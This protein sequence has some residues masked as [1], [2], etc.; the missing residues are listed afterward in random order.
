[1]AQP[2]FVQLPV[3]LSQHEI[4]TLGKGAFVAKQPLFP[5]HTADQMFK[6]DSDKSRGSA[7]P[8]DVGQIERQITFFD[9]GIINK[10]ATEKQGGNNGMRGTITCFGGKP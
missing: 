8:G 5:H 2:S 4:S 7:M 1:M 9:M 10:I 6:P 3:D